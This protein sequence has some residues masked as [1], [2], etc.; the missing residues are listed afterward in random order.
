MVLVSNVDRLLAEAR[1]MSAEER[2][3]LADRILE[4]VPEVIAPE[5]DQ[6]ALEELHRRREKI[7]SGETELLGWDDVRASLLSK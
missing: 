4:L 5:L 7:A 6:A 1:S 3:E 2:A